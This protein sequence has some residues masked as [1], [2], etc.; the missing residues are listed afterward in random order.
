MSIYIFF[1]IMLFCLLGTYLCSIQYIKYLR[2]EISR[3]I[4]DIDL[5]LV[6]ILFGGP[7]LFA[8]WCAFDEIRTEDKFNHYRVLI[9]SIVL[10]VIQITIIVLLFVF[11]VIQLAP[12]V[13]Q[14]SATAMGIFN[15]YNSSIS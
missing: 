12:S 15:F 13:T 6:S 1:T 8:M 7:V 10:S 4:R 11:G 9:S 2:K 14:E 5:I 3:K